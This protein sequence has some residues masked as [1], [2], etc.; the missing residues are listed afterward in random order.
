MF[1]VVKYFKRDMLLKK[2]MLSQV[3]NNQINKNSYY[4]DNSQDKDE[5]EGVGVQE[6]VQLFRKN[7][8]QELFKSRFFLN[9]AFGSY[10]SGIRRDSM[11]LTDNFL[12]RIRSIFSSFLNGSFLCFLNFFGLFLSRLIDKIKE[13]IYPIINEPAKYHEN[14]NNN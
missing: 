11:I 10:I 8:N 2:F 5:K 3:I 14:Y 7:T 13:N 12:F 9:D 1:Q 4:W 6:V